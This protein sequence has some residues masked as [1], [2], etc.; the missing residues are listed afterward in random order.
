MAAIANLKQAVPFF[1]VSKLAAS[2][3]FYKDGLGFELKS[4]WSPNEKIEWCWLERDGVAF[5]L[6]EYRAG[7]HPAGTPGSGVSICIMCNDALA[8]YEEFLKKEIH[9][10]EP[11]VGNQLWVIEV[12]DPDGYAIIFESPTDLPEETTYTQWLVQKGKH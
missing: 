6:Q 9:V 3:V 7:L 12:R 4:S 5:M 1:W 10:K 2:L 8:L 11:F